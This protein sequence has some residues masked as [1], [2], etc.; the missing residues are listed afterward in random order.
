M[1]KINP[2]L[3]Q[4]FAETSENIIATNSIFNKAIAQRKS[5]VVKKKG[6]GFEI[7]K[8]ALRRSLQAHMVLFEL[9]HP[10]SFNYRQAK[11]IAD[12]LDRQPGKIF[13]SQTH[14]L[15]NDR[16]ALLLCE[17]STSGHQEV[18]ISLQDSHATFLTK[19]FTLEVLDAENILI[20]TGRNLAYLDMELLA[21]PLKIR[22]W[23]HG[24]YFY[25]L[26]MTSK[27]K[28]SDFMI[29]EKIPVNL[30]SQLI[31]IFSG[32]DLIWVVGYRID[33][34]YRIT[35]KTRKILKISTDIGHD[36]SI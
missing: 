28:V 35:K 15:I 5:E 34:R 16:M 24:D 21:F 14:R 33:N 6:N 18:L 8:E 4:T 20:D 30:K 25:P 29:D 36:Q 12:D 19:H 22:T 31:T 2:N 32:E 9:L 23:K 17:I 26:G 13:Y 7:D 11:D 10:F 27:K 1:K 3:E